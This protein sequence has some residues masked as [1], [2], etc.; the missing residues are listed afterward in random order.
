MRYP[1]YCSCRKCRKIYYIANIVRHF[2]NCNNISEYSSKACLY[3]SK[4]LKSKRQESNHIRQ[5]KNN[6]NRVIHKGEN[7]YTKARKNGIS[8]PKMSDYTKEKIRNSSLGRKHSDKSKEKISIAARKSNHRRIRKNTILYNGVLLDS[9]YELQVAQN[10]DK[11]NILW[12]RPH[13][14]TYIDDQ[15]YSRKYYPDFYLPKYS[16][17]LDPKNDYLIKTD[18]RKI[19][20]A[21]IQN[22]VKII[23]LDKNNLNWCPER[24]SNPH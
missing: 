13:P 11:L 5:C 23:I 7:Q 1:I 4:P 6:P 15:G 9:T 20:L 16:L 14:L 24:D 10:L 8:I 18:T 17:Y 19:E 22:N 2:D 3:C 21:E 12:I